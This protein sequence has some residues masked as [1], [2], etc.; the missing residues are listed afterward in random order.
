M[1][2]IKMARKS[3]HVDMTAMTDVAFLLLTFFMLATKFRPDEPVDIRTP[4]STSTTQIP[5]GFM[6][7]TLDKEG[8]VFF[9]VDNLNAKKELIDQ[10]D[11]DKGLNL[12]KTEK[13]EFVTSAAVPVPFNQLKSF[14]EL[15]AKDQEAYY[16]SAPGIPT[17]TTGDYETNELAYWIKTTSY[18]LGPNFRVAIKADGE[19]KYPEI[20]KVISTLGKLKIFRFN[21]ITDMKG[22]PPGTALYDEQHP[23][24]AVAN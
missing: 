18:Y 6:L 23:N 1:P 24:A 12:T 10:I 15:P 16:G 8:R 9:S 7:I 2:K 19:A 20:Q 21:F 4:A 11:T 3:T 13:A 5:E 14:L 22:V 17:D